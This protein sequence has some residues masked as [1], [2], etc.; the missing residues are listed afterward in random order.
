MIVAASLL[1]RIVKSQLPP[2]TGVRCGSETCR[3]RAQGRYPQVVL[4]GAGYDGRALRFSDLALSWIEIDHPATQ[5][6]KLQRLGRLGANTSHISFVSLDLM[7]GDLD[8]E[9]AKAG[10]DSSQPSLWICEGLFPYLPSH[11]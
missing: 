4:L 11:Q 2:D 5:A 8:A 3:Y 1:G 7:S 9:L 6:D 10:H